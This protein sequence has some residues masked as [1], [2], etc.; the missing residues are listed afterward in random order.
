MQIDEDG[1]GLLD[2]DEIAHMALNLGQKLTAKQLDAA[3][4]EMDEVAL[5]PAKP[6]PHCCCC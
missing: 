5:V 6:R 2:R 4:M 1:S 3:I